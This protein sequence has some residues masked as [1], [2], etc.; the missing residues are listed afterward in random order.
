[1]NDSTAA[2]AAS[3]NSASATAGRIA[4]SIPTIAP[5]NAFTTTSR[6]NWPRL[7]RRPRFTSERNDGS[8]A[9]FKQSIEYNARPRSSSVPAAGGS[10]RGGQLRRGPR[11]ARTD[12]RRDHR[13]L[14]DRDGVAEHALAPREERHHAHHPVGGRATRQHA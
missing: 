1:M 5:T 14:R 10:N 13:P 3:W 6:E 7:A 9:I 8:E 11:L 12:A 2:R 4:R